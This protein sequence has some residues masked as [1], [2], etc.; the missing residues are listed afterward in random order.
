VRVIMTLLTLSLGCSAKDGA[1]PEGPAGSVASED[2]SRALDQ[3]PDD[4]DAPRAP[5][6]PAETLA[7]LSEH[8]GF[9][10][11]PIPTEAAPFPEPLVIRSAEAFAA[12]ITRIPA[13][14]PQKR[15][16]AP[17]NP[18]PLLAEPDIDW[19]RSMM[20]VVLSDWMHVQPELRAVRDDG[21]RLLVSAHV[22][23]RGESAMFAAV[24]D[25]GR[26]HAWVVPRRDGL[27]EFDVDRPAEPP[28]P[29]E[30]ADPADMLR[31][32]D[33]D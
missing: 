21:A 20:V 29:G 5:K 7:P 1:G 4:P 22:P 32:P 10:R 6:T 15:Q 13:T 28:W 19:S 27:V 33:A 30:P 9:A 25:L 16:P 3:P 12:F 2:E 17:A 24:I 8:S 14:L 31:P 26:Y 23:H 18:D 11:I